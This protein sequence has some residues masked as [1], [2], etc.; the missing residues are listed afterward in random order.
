MKSTQKIGLNNLKLALRTYWHLLKFSHI[1]TN[2]FLY[3]HWFVLYAF[4]CT[5][6]YK[7][8]IYYLFL[9]FLFSLSFSQVIPWNSES[10]KVLWTLRKYYDVKKN[11]CFRKWHFDVLW[12]L[13]V[14]TM[15]CT[16]KCRNFLTFFLY[17]I[18]FPIFFWS[19]SIYFFFKKGVN[20]GKKQFYSIF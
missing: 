12:K 15:M 17:H 1:G 4:C 20:K 6:T 2:H 7:Y 19:V 5:Y 11:S 8:F 14:S 13:T 18:F 3:Y 10:P 9:C 16:K